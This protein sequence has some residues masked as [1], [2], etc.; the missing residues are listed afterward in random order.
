MACSEISGVIILNEG[1]VAKLDS[2]VKINSTILLDKRTRHSSMAGGA[3]RVN[4][5]PDVHPLK[6]TLQLINF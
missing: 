3:E 5:V 6:I 2:F 1:R 4:M